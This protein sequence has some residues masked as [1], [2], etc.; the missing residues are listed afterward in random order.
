MRSSV[1][2]R[3]TRLNVGRGFRRYATGRPGWGAIGLT[4]CIQNGGYGRQNRE[5][6]GTAS[7]RDAELDLFRVLQRLIRRF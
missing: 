4:L 2:K 7:A 1:P 6:F 5:R 3:G